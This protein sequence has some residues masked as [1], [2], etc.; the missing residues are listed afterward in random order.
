MIKMPPLHGFFH[1]GFRLGAHAQMV[2]VPEHTDDGLTVQL[3]S[4]VVSGGER[5]GQSR[6][7]NLRQLWHEK[8]SLGKDML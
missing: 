7:A 4:P 3:R 5:F 2:F 6:F 8:T 1:G